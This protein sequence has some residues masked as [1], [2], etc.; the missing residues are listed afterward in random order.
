M[1]ECFDSHKVGVSNFA[2]GKCV[3]D[4]LPTDPRLTRSGCDRDE[5][6]VSIQVADFVASVAFCRRG[7]FLVHLQF[8]PVSEH[9]ST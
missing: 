9:D 6:G 2:E 7:R 8:L 3:S 5:W 4:D 1:I